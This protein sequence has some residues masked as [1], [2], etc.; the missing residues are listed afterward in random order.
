MR[1]I[2][3]K[4][5]LTDSGIAKFRNFAEIAKNN[6]NKL[7][8]DLEDRIKDAIAKYAP[9]EAGELYQL[10]LPGTPYDIYKNGFLSVQQAIKM[11]VIPVEI[12]GDKVYAMYGDPDKM[13]PQIGFVWFKGKKGK[14][15]KRSTADG[16]AG[17]A[18][19]SLLQKWEW[20]GSFTVVS[21]D[22]G[23]QLTI[24]MQGKTPIRAESALKTIPAYNMYQSGG[25]DGYHILLSEAKQALEAG[26]KQSGF[27]IGAR[28]RL[29]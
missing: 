1:P 22:E 15:E 11:E 20:G 8:C 2:I 17:E 12:A 5:T 23:G 9:S 19:K 4:I 16:A 3:N 13:N 29:I 27:K 10:S 28:T 24:A 14:S 26:L 21:R 6:L 18:W 7:L 25:E